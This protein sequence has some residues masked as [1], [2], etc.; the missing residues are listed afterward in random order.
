[1]TLDT[2]FRSKLKYN[3]GV[4]T[5]SGFTLKSETIQ[6]DTKRFKKKNNGT[7]VFKTLELGY[8]RWSINDKKQVR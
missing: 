5:G 8:K 7:I 4:L 6:K 2:I 3:K 1:M